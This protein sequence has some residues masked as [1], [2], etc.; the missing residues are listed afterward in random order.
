MSARSPAPTAER[1][2]D[3]VSKGGGVLIRFAGERMPGGTDDLVPVKLR[4]GGRYL[5]SAMAWSAPQHLARFRRPQS[6][7]RTG[8]ARA[9]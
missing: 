1:W 2:K 7:Q 4:V 3:F 8:G 6:V 5:G 9:K